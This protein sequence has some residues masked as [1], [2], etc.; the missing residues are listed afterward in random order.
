MYFVSSV[1]LMRMSMPLEYRSIV[2][3]VLGELQFNFY[4]RWFDVIFLVSALSSIL[5]LYLAHKQAPEKHMTFWSS[6]SYAHVTPVSFHL[7]F[8]D[9]QKS[10]FW[11]YTS[12]IRNGWLLDAGDGELLRHTR[13]QLW[14]WTHLNESIYRNKCYR[15]ELCS[16]FIFQ[17]LCALKFRSLW[18]KWF[19]SLFLPN[20]LELYS[21]QHTPGRW[22]RFPVLQNCLYVSEKTQD[23]NK[24]FVATDIVILVSGLS[25]AVTQQVLRGPN[26][27]RQKLF[28]LV[29][30]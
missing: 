29:S 25:R 28:Y 18:P 30:F 12:W 8:R 26:K 11:P 16:S 17:I 15:L 1:L 23:C 13:E 3:E 24:S 21:S 7:E 27:P 2:S 6:A 4:H 19:F 22:W 9:I 14:K 5:F 20:T 10:L